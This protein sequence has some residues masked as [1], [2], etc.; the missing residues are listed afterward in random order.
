[1]QDVFQNTGVLAG[2]DQADEEF[3]ELKR[4]LGE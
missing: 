3:V 2:G 4:V 1:M